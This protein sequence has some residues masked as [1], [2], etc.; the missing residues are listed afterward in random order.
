[1]IK[2]RILWFQDGVKFTTPISKWNK[3]DMLTQNLIT[4]AGN[5][6]FEHVIVDPISCAQKLFQQIDVK[7]YSCVVDLSGFFGKTIR[8][9]FPEVSV[10]DSFRLSRVRMVSSP[11][12]DGSGFLVSLSSQQIKNLKDN[13]DLNRPL[14]L[15]DVAWSGRTI[16]EGIK[17]LGLDPTITTVGLLSTNEGD[18]GEGKPGASGILKEKGIRILSGEIISTPQD[19]GFHLADFLNFIPDENVFD[20]ILKIWEREGTE[21]EKKIILIN[22]KD[23]LFPKAISSEEMRLLQQEGRLYQ[24]EWDS[25]KSN[26]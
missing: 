9:N 24:Y 22:N 7:E 19:D 1:M 17:I 11:R 21:N 5:R 26:I 3:I 25:Q 12:L 10:V 2:Q 14:L 16:V 4:L 6:N 8:K 23:A 20:D 18:F 13:I 15:D